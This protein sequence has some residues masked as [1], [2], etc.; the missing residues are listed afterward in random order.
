M[1]NKRERFKLSV[2]VFLFL[3]KE[4]QILLIKRANTSWMDGFYSVPAG[5]LDGNEALDFG[6][7]REA[8][9]E[10]DV[11]VKIENIELVHTIHCI[12]SGEEWMGTFF[13]TDKFEGEPKVNEPHKHSEVKWCDIDNLPE[14]IIPYVRQAIENYRGKKYYSEYR[15][16]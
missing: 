14:N 11:N 6:A 8:K 5:S 16:E 15:S 7:C 10:T 12:T 4:N 3:I 13:A 2:A 1:S 9:E